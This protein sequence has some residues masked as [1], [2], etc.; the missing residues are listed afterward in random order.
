MRLVQQ[1]G[2]IV[3]GVLALGLPAAAA[4]GI[5]RRLALDS[6]PEARRAV[7][8]VLA[9][10]EVLNTSAC[11][12]QAGIDR[13]VARMTLEDLAAIGVVANDRQDEDTDDQEAVVNWSLLGED[14]AIIAGVFKAFHQS[15]GGWDEM[16]V[17]TSTSPPIRAAESTSTGGQPTLRPTP[18]LSGNGDGPPAKPASHCERCGDELTNPIQQQRR[19]CGPCIVSEVMST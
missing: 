9:T 4:G 1:L 17:Y 16:W 15:R 13:K 7:L 6:M 14:G 8:Q 5:A 3:R 2:G 19:R 10:G 11:A 18:A 12:R